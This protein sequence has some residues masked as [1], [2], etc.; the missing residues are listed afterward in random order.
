V[1]LLVDAG[2]DVFTAGSFTSATALHKACQGGS[3]EITTMLLDRGAHIEASRRRWAI[4]RSWTPCG[5]NG[6]ELVKLLVDRGQKLS[7]VTN[8]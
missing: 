2:A 8:S 7:A 5:K 1:R 4:R 3:V 6:P